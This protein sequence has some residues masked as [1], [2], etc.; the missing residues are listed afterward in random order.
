MMLTFSGN[1]TTHVNEPLFRLFHY[2]FVAKN[3]YFDSV[4]Y[5]FISMK[6]INFDVRSGIDYSLSLLCATACI[7]CSTIHWNEFNVLST[8]SVYSL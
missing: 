2:Y 5:Y 1:I 3:L 7:L 8:L 4:P 6:I